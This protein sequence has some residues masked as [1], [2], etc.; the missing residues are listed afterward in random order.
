[1]LLYITYNRSKKSLIIIKLLY[2]LLTSISVNQEEKE[3]KRLER[4]RS[5]MSF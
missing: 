2:N 4:Y 3:V 5:I 1:M